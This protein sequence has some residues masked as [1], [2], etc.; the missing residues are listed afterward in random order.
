[1]SQNRV[2]VRYFHRK[3]YVLEV[4]STRELYTLY[5]AVYIRIHSD[6]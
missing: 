6:E 5:S 3:C 2:A 1:M 4:E